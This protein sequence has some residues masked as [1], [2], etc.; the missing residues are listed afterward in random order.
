MLKDYLNEKKI[1]MYKVSKESG[2]PYSTLN[3]LV[4][5]RVDIDSCKVAL[6]LRLSRYLGMSMD[7][8]YDVISGGQTSDH[9]YQNNLEISITASASPNCDTSKLPATPN[10]SDKDRLEVP[11]SDILLPDFEALLHERFA[12]G[13]Y[14]AKAAENKQSVLQLMISS[15]RKEDEN[16][17]DFLRRICKKGKMPDDVFKKGFAYIVITDYLLMQQGRSLENVFIETEDNGDFKRFVIPSS[18]GKILFLERD[19]ESGALISEKAA[20][21]DDVTNLDISF[22]KKKERK[23]LKLVAEKSVIEKE[24][25][26]AKEE[27]EK[28]LTESNLSS[29]KIKK[30]CNWYQERLDALLLWMEE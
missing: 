7:A 4:N 10:A 12:P 6:F 24:K 13:K 9:Q 15:D 2:V 17:F 20:K 25:L 26:P 21:F 16:D 1:S 8:L 29:K 5:G 3:D 14:I 22:L 30:I 19:T 28:L 27:L 23:L 18:T 11:S